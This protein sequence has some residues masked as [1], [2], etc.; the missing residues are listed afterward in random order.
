MNSMMQQRVQRK[1]FAAS[2]TKGANGT[3]IFT[4]STPDLD[5]DMDRIDPKGWNLTQYQDENPIVLFAHDQKS[6]PIGRCTDIR[7][8]GHNLKAVVEWAPNGIYPL[9]DTVHGLVDAG[10]LRSASVGF[11]A[12][13][14]EP[15]AYGGQDIKAA[16][17]LEWSVVNIGSNPSAMLERGVDT[18]RLKSWLGNSWH[19]QSKEDEMYLEISD[20]FFTKTGDDAFDE[21]LARMRRQYQ[22]MEGGKF[23]E[24][25]ARQIALL[26]PNASIAALMRAVAGDGVA[27]PKHWRGDDDL[28]DIDEKELATLIAGVIAETTGT[29]VRAA[30][31]TAL[32]RLD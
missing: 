17:L 25:M 24:L 9:A 12:D 30:L 10:F 14:S 16:T 19:E 27:A 22:E 3:N 15:N 21:M 13:R 5:R 4:V 28:L 11:R 29:Q 18:M 26:G 20:D 1:V 31:N 23:I 6:P 2:A 7:V 32:G 8:V